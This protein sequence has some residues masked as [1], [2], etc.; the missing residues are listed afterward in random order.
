MKKYILIG[1]VLGTG[2]SLFLYYLQR[3]RSEGMEFR[4]FVGSSGTADDMFGNAFQQ[5]PDKL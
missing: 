2:V 4:D 3:K 5:S 1:L